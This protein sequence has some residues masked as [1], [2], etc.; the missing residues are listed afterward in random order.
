MEVTLVATKDSNAQVITT[1][2]RRFDYF[3]YEQKTII[4]KKFIRERPYASGNDYQKVEIDWFDYDPDH[5]WLLVRLHVSEKYSR[6]LFKN[7]HDC[8]IKKYG[9]D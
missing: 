7:V 1:L 3:K 9:G 5:K 2:K 6:I 4:V 8:F